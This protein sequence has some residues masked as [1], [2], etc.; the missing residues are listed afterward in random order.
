MGTSLALIPQPGN[1]S[2]GGK[3]ATLGT[4][5]EGWGVHS[6]WV[7]SEIFHSIFVTIF[8]RTTILSG[9]CQKGDQSLAD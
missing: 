8:N 3:S 2:L 6:L 1:V 5:L 9:E 7:F 4:G